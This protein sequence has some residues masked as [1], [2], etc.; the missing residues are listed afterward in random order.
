MVDDDDAFAQGFE[1]ARVMRGEQHTNVLEPR[2]F[3]DRVADVLLGNHVQADGGL[4]EQDQLR[5]VQERGCH[6]TPHPLTERKF[7]HR[8]LQEILNLERFRDLPD[9]DFRLA[10]VHLIDLS[11]EGERVDGRQVIPKLRALAKDRAD[12]IGKL[13]AFLPG[14]ITKHLRI[15]AGWMQDACE[16]FDRGGFPG[17]VWT[18]E[19]EQ[20][21]GF[22][23]ECKTAHG[24]DGAVFRFEERAHGAAHPGGFAFGLEGFLEVGRLRW[25]ACFIYPYD[26]VTRIVIVVEEMVHV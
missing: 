25:R 17:A 12:V 22:H 15:A 5:A 18:D 13:L 19:T 24:F 7:P 26:S 16:H 9:A 1:I 10:V 4:I 23:L 20:F 14:D 8:S 2:H 11:E 3:T 6:L 21:A